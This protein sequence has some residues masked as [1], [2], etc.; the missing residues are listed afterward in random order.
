MHRPLAVP[1]DLAAALRAA[2]G[3][4]YWALAAPGRRL[5]AGGALAG[6]AR[7]TLAVW[8]APGAPALAP[9][10]P[11]LLVLGPFPATALAARLG[12]LGTPAPSLPPTPVVPALRALL[13]APPTSIAGVAPGV[14]AALGLG[15]LYVDGTAPPI[16]FLRTTAVRDVR[17]LLLAVGER[18]AA[19]AF[20]WLAALAHDDG[21]ATGLAEAGEDE[22][23]SGGASGGGAAAAAAGAG[24]AG[25]ASPETTPASL[26]TTPASAGGS[27]A[28]GSGTPKGTKAF[29]Q[30]VVLLDS[31]GDADARIGFA[32]GSR[33]RYS[34]SRLLDDA[35]DALRPDAST[36]LPP[37]M[38]ATL[39]WRDATAAPDAPPAS[40]TAVEAPPGGNN[41]VHE[42]RLTVPR[43]APLAPS[44]L[45]PLLRHLMA[46]SLVS[47]PS[48]T[49]APLLMGSPAAVAALDGAVRELYYPAAN[50]ARIVV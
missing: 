7:C 50:Y 21:S 2:G 38:R 48:S 49:T 11:A 45:V 29:G 33:R 19:M 22:D 26:S 14:S 20:A 30:V 46:A 9:T 4:A 44:Q 24:A 6:G 8:G 25:M 42:C 31:D 18:A 13:D 3:A 1:F 32:T 41:K 16:A 47:A 23:G 35:F 36:A 15:G 34:A 28:S 12:L 17:P 43:D 37:F 10:T 5:A 27:P 40:L 39:V